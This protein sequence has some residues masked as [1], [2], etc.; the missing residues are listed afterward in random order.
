MLATP[1]ETEPRYLVFDTQLLVGG[2]HRFSITPEE[3][4]FAALTLYMDIVLLFL[5]ILEI[6]GRATGSRNSSSSYV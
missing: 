3:Y 4:I 2:G 6:V 1:T 5:Y